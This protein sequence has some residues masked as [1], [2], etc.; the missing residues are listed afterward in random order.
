VYRVLWGTRWERKHWEDL[1]VD[2]RIILGWI[3]ERGVVETCNGLGWVW[4][5]TVGVRL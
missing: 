2:G 1:R 5:G 4:I 3:T